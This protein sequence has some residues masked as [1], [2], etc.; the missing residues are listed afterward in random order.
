MPPTLPIHAPAP[1]PSYL[2]LAHIYE[3]FNFTLV[4]HY[5]AAAG[6][7]RCARS[8]RAAGDHASGLGAGW[9]QRVRARGA[10]CC[11]LHPPPATISIPR[12]SHTT[13]HHHHRGN[14]LEL[15]EDIQE[16]RP[17]IFSSVPRLW[18]RIYDKVMA[19]ARG[20]AALS[21]LPRNNYAVLECFHRLGCP[22]TSRQPA[23]GLHTSSSSRSHA[24]NPQ[25][26]IQ[27]ANPI[28]R[29]L[30][31]TAYRYKQVGGWLAGS[32]GEK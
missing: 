23:P 9:P 17:T 24:S 10:R 25:P 4:T 1:L 31:N 29:S 11:T 7:Y 26:Q 14:V 18:N 8:A 19:Q 2:P 28:S 15:L 5:G 6:F 21:T 22:L 30:F 13:S 16:L 27:A 12:R 3:R 20:W 32:V